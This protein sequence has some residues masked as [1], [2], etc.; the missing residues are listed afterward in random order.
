M[1]FWGQ[2]EEVEW[3]GSVKAY[4]HYSLIDLLLVSSQKK[5]SISQSRLDL[6]SG[7]SLQSRYPYI[8]WCAQVENISG[9]VVMTGGPGSKGWDG[10]LVIFIASECGSMVGQYVFAE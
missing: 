5:N 6:S 1:S 3:S 7:L 4:S 10:I 2:E 9:S 8:T